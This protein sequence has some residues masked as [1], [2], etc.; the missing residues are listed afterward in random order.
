MTEKDSPDNSL[1]TDSDYW[2]ERVLIKLRSLYL[3]GRLSFHK[4]N[5]KPLKWQPDFNVVLKKNE[6]GM[7]VKDG[8][9]LNEKTETPDF[10]PKK[11]LE[12]Y[13]SPEYKALQALSSAGV[14]KI[15]LYKNQVIKER[16]IGISINYPL[17]NGAQ[18]EQF[19][20]QKFLQ[21][22]KLYG[23][24]PTSMNDSRRQQVVS[25]SVEQTATADTNYVGVAQINYE[26]YMTYVAL[27]NEKQPLK[28]RKLDIK[29]SSGYDHFLNYMFEPKNEGK[30][31]T[32]KDVQALHIKC[33][34]YADMGELLRYCGFGITLKRVF[35]PKRRDHDGFIYHKQMPV[36]EKQVEDIKKAIAKIVA[37]S[38]EL[39]FNRGSFLHDINWTWVK[40]EP[41]DL[42]K[43]LH[44]QLPTQ[45]MQQQRTWH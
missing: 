43:W 22:C 17:V 13:Y 27:P 4:G 36:T 34:P 39:S 2:I 9:V 11:T 38:W 3:S 14:I 44:D 5:D 6:E 26:D 19:D 10:Y 21:Q 15:S 28:L 1:P 33:E 20:Y 37:K 12:N 29:P 31:I 8:F 32:N 16:F 18:I 30:L 42:Q 45:F 23:I 40:R 41:V 7:I 24:S 25:G 35:M